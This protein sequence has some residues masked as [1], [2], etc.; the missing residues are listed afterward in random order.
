MAAET[1][2]DLT[3]VRSGATG[4][5]VTPEATYDDLWLPLPGRHQLDN[6][7]LAVRGAERFLARE[8]LGTLDPE[9]VRQGVAAVRWP[10]RLEWLPPEDA[11]PRVL[12]DAAHNP[13]GAERLAEFL[14]SLGSNGR[15]VLVFGTSRDKRVGAMLASL[16]PHFGRVVLTAAATR[17][18]LPLEEL[19]AAAEPI[20]A[21]NGAPAET[22]E[23]VPAALER[24]FRLAGGN[25]EVVVAGSIFLLGDA[26]RV[27]RSESGDGLADDVIEMP[28]LPSEPIGQTANERRTSAA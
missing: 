16:A 23:N 25:G 17:R 10:G 13:S 28:A 24:A 18:A 6:L 5:L 21:G 9:R 26:L 12:L 3:I 27:L 2:T 1:E 7:A 15:R 22:V 14:E 8:N 4:R 20:L 19:S 11:R